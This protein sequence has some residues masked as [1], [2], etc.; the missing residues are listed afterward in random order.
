MLRQQAEEQLELE[1]QE[2]NRQLK[3]LQADL[4][5]EREKSIVLEKELGCQSLRAHQTEEELR[6]RIE[7]L[8]L[9][10]DTLQAHELEKE[11]YSKYW[12]SPL[13]GSSKKQGVF[14]II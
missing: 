5:E 6:R 10:R 2:L 14:T 9:L 13:P 11:N 1:K 12:G 8:E 4:R 3:R 7:E